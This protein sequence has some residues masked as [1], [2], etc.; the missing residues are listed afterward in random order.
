MFRDR[1]QEGL[2][3]QGCIQLSEKYFEPARAGHKSM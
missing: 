1:Y 3:V 2:R